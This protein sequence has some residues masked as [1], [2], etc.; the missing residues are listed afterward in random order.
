MEALR[1][2]N[3]ALAWEA[4]RLLSSRWETKLGMPE[5]MVGSM[6]TI[7]LPERMGSTDEDAALLRDALLFE[8]RIEI[9]L[10]ARRG[11]LWVRLSA[12]IYNDLA[13]VERLDAAIRARS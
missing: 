12:Q 7:P 9:Q 5:S 11:R 3:H 1:E 10:H 13:D 4:A 6:A 8:D 2:Y